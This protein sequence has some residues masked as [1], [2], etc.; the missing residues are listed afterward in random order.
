MRSYKSSNINSA[1][2]IEYLERLVRKEGQ[3]RLE[4]VED[5]IMLRVGPAGFMNA[6][7]KRCI[8]DCEAVTGSLLDA[9]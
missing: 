3:V 7:L 2:A 8:A 4:K 1:W 6:D 5:C 9:E